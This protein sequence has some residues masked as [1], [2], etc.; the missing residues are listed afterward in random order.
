M[1]NQDLI[2]CLVEESGADINQPTNSGN[3]P[4]F[5]AAQNGKVAAVRYLAD[6][7]GTNVNHANVE[8]A[9]SL[10]ITA[11]HGYLDVLKCLVN[12]FG[13][14]INKGRPDGATPLMAA[15][16]YKY[17]EVVRWLLKNGA[18]AQTKLENSLTA[19]D[20]SKSNGAPDESTAYLEARTYCANTGC[21]G[22]GLKKC[23]NCLEVYFCSKECQVVAWPAHKADCKGRVEANVGKK[24]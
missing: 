19:A 17:N 16:K 4:L 5:V 3:T 20:I 22:A 23:A 10:C 6:K 13:A 21:S 18:N 15:S 12:E 2:R 1:L 11:Q 7:L 24:K 14:N 9:T 8:G